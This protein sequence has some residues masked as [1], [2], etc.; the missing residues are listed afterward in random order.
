MV[1]WIVLGVVVATV[2]VVTV[3]TFRSFKKWHEPPRPGGPHEGDAT[4][5]W[6]TYSGGDAN[7]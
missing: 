7:P 6:M 2:L 4:L 3:L 5:T 1:G